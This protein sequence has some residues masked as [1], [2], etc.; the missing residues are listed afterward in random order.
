MTNLLILYRYFLRLLQNTSIM[1]NIK[2]SITIT[3]KFTNIL[4]YN[5]YIIYSKMQYTEKCLPRN[6]KGCPV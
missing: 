4:L 2:V 5:S 6:N 3:N 1:N